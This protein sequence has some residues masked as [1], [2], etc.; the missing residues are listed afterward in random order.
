MSPAFNHPAESPPQWQFPW[1]LVLGGVFAALG[2]AG[3]FKA[4]GGDFG[5]LLQSLEERQLGTSDSDGKFAENDNIPAAL[6]TLVTEADQFWGTQEFPEGAVYRRPR[7]TAFYGSDESPCHELQ[8]VTGPFYCFVDEKLSFDAEFNEELITRFDAAGELARAYIVGHLFGHHI[9]NRLGTTDR[10]RDQLSQ[11]AT[12]PAGK[13]KLQRQ[14]ELQADYF[15]GVWAHRSVEFGKLLDASKLE[16]ALE[17][18]D[19]LVEE[20]R[21]RELTVPERFG[22]GQVAERADWFRRGF[23]SGDMHE[24][25][26]FQSRDP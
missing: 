16:T 1:K 4:A 22:P 3:L 17:A 10:V 8:V 9:Q 12:S 20:R 7:V 6:M 18:I 24:H 25:D 5:E 21:K 13:R 15:A 26:P 11:E 19:K 2:I 14:L 23:E